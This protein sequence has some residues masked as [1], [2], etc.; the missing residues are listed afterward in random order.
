MLINY[1][2]MFGRIPKISIRNYSYKTN[3]TILNA[4]EKVYLGMKGFGNEEI[5]KITFDFEHTPHGESD[6]ER[7]DCLEEVSNNYKEIGI[8]WTPTEE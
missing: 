8:N 4:N 5:K 3:N 6:K 7:M 1:K 2:K